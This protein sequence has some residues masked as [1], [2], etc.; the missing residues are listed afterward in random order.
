[1]NPPTARQRLAEPNSKRIKE[2]I[3]ENSIK[4]EIK[5][6]AELS[7]LDRGCPD[8]GTIGKWTIKVGII[9][10]IVS[11]TRNSPAMKDFEHPFDFAVTHTCL[12]CGHVL[13]ET[14]KPSN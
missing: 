2:M 9:N 12:H 11:K 6:G 7:A 14:V 10:N 4:D 13:I 3:I 5:S 8:C 1:M